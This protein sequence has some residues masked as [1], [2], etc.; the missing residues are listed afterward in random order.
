MPNQ[1]VFPFKRT[2]PAAVKASLREYIQA[3]HTDTHPDAFK[4]DISRWDT[5]RKEALGG[6]VHESSVDSALEYHAQLVFILTKLPPDIGLSITYY[7]AFPSST[8]QLLTLPNLFY[9]RACVLF[10]LASLYCQLASAQDRIS[11]EGIKRASNQFQLSAGVL[12]YLIAEVLPPL[13][14]SLESSQTPTSLPPDLSEPFLLSLE[15]LMLAQAQECSWQKAVSGKLAHYSLHPQYLTLIRAADQLK[16]GVVAKLASQVSIFYSSSLSALDS[17]PAS[18]KSTF[19]Q[20]W[21]PHLQTKMHH[22]DAAAQYRKSLDEADSNNY[23]NQ[24]GRLQIA[25]VAANKAADIARK[26]RVQ[27]NVQEDVKSLVGMIGIDLARVDRDNGL[28]YHQDVPA[29][30]SLPPVPGAAIARLVSPPGLSNPSSVVGTEVILGGL[31]GWGVRTACDIYNDRKNNWIR[32]EILDVQRQLDA[33]SSQTLSSLNLPSSLDALQKPIGLPPSLLRKAEEVRLEGAEE[34]V[35]HTI[36]DIHRLRD[37]CRETIE[38]ALDILDAEATEDEQYRDAFKEDEWTRTPSHEANW[39][40][41]DQATRYRD[42]LDRAGESDAVVENKWEEWE[43]RVKVLGWDEAKIEATVPTTT[44]SSSSARS[45]KT[46]SSQT[47]KHVRNLR[48]SLEVLD[49]ILLARSTLVS[50]VQQFASGDDIK[51]RIMRE[52]AGIERWIEVNPA[53]FEDTLEEEMGKY[54]RYREKMEQSKASQEELL[55]KIKTQNELFLQSRKDDPA[56]KAR[57]QALQSLDIAYHRYREICGNLEEGLKF[58]NDFTGILCKFRDSCKEW[59]RQR[60]E[61]V[62]WLTDSFGHV[63]L[64]PTTA[65][66]VQEAEPSPES[67]PPRAQELSLGSP[68][69]VHPPV[70]MKSRPVLDLPPPDSDEWEET[71]MFHPPQPPSHPPAPPQDAS[72]HAPAGGAGASAEMDRERTV[73]RSKRTRTSVLPGR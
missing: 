12:S 67:S 5:L 39:E 37:I 41:T 28:I 63:S 33:N 70:V 30:S 34:K 55:E 73:R 18:V 35:N 20:G 50:Q 15:W 23:G 7:P 22:F 21:I 17:A 25:Q 19:P 68:S 47:Q 61:D 14:S 60:R 8:S 64:T 27:K 66:S 44:H 71:P 43:D 10:N 52:A 32:E 11:A 72:V 56:V 6:Q 24:I 38:E 4:W 36:E 51:P 2:A 1:L 59:V 42:V 31:E 46:S 53:M 9:E 57:E 40:L 65:S 54:E 62:S 3:N 16:N 58:Y 49:D 26:G 69:P 13:Q 29:I 48:S 45:L